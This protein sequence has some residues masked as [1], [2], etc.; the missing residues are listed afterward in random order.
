MKEFRLAAVFSS[1]MVLQRDKK[2]CVFGEGPE[3][4]KVTVEFAGQ[5]METR[6][7][8][9]RWQV[10]LSPMKAGVRGE[11]VAVCGTRYHIFTDVCVG[12]VWLAGGQSNM[13][14]ELSRS[15]GGKEALAGEEPDVRYYQV[16]RLSWKNDNFCE[17]EAASAWELFSEEKAGKWSAVAFYFAQRI[18]RELGVTVGIIGCSWGG[19][20]AAAW[21][22]ENVLQEDSVLRIYWE[23]Y[24]ETVEGVSQEQQLR[25]YEE[26]ETYFEQWNR[27]AMEYWRKFP[28]LTWQEVE[29]DCGD[30]RWPGPVNCV[31]PFRPSGLYHC[32]LERV[33]PY[34]MKGFLYYQGEA[35]EARAGMYGRLLGRLIEQWR[36]DWEE[37][38]MPFLLVQL[39]G[40]QNPLREDDRSWCI[41]REAQMQV[42]HTI[43][44]TGI[45]VI[46]DC[47]D[48]NEIHPA[49]KR[50]VGR[51]LSLQALCE[52]YGV[53]D[54]EEAFGPVYRTSYPCEDKM[55]VE[56]D[57]TG[58]GIQLREY[59]EEAAPFEIAGEDKIFRK[60]NAEVKGGKL[61][62]WSD[63]IK[64]P[65]Y[66]RY[67][68]HNFSVPVVF[69][70]NGIPAAPFRTSKN[71]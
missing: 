3:G 13:E 21:V 57:Y 24:E 37:E 10:I 32:M 6:I 59:G 39:P 63:E 18:S 16:P 12:E 30:S 33:M 68:W 71:D 1:H 5:L 62:V 8:E 9:E 40:Y 11:L 2:V 29:R 47:G 19:T 65:M 66:V 44:K 23:E 45:A 7:K 55:E 48:K 70:M 54:K 41:I 34:T 52:I 49:D 27:K 4:E 20:S 28:E 17:E 46:L 26:Y 69:G 43:K 60:A 53:I 56:F 22:P 58:R 38:N 42:C 14:Y 50:E 35:D 36:T 64:M 25:E 61:L 67:C 31:H 15:V 51:R